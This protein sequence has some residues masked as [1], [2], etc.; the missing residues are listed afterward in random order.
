MSAST[1]AYGPEIETERLVLRPF[2]PEDIQAFVGYRS[3][4]EVAR[5]QSWDHTYSPLDG[6]RFLAS[7][8]GRAF[9]APGDWMQM[10]VVD[11]VRGALCGDCAV[12][13]TREQ[14]ATAEVGVTFAPSSQGRGLAGEALAAV[15]GRFV[16]GARPAPGLR[17]G[18]RSQRPRAPA[19]RAPW[20]PPRSAPRR[21]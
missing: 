9:G 14:P 15:I 12:R 2:M 18:R 6:E 5:F 1:G 8:E 7:Q 11:R 3:D 21:G 16:R 10:A 20:L 13:V 19:A 17:A 4:P